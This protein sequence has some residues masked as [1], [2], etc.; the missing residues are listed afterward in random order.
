MIK[1]T[2]KNCTHP[3][4]KQQQQ[5][6][7]TSFSFTDSDTVSVSLFCRCHEPASNKV[8]KAGMKLLLAQWQ[9]PLLPK[10]FSNS[11]NTE[12]FIFRYDFTHRWGNAPFTVWCCPWCPIPA[13]FPTQAELHQI[14]VEVLHWFYKGVSSVQSKSICS[15]KPSEVKHDEVWSP[16]W[17]TV[18]CYILCPP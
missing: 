1:L 4:K 2:W 9:L 10:A 18:I 8:A 3:P 5:Q 17:V 14:W 11:T 15:W 12:G 16:W 6:T 7:T 13:G